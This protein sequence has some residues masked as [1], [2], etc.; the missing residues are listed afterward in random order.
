LKVGNNLIEPTRHA[1]LFTL[2]QG[3]VPENRRASVT[4]YLMA[5]PPT[6]N[7]IMQYYYFFKQQYAAD[8]ATQDLAVL[9]KMRA[10]WKDMANS[11][12]EASFEV[13][14]SWEATQA[15]CYGMFPAYFLSSYVL[16]VRLDGPV[17]KKSLIIE[18]RLADLTEASGTVE[19]EF[20][21]ASVS[22]KLEDGQWNYSVDT[23]KLPPDISVHLRLPVEAKTFS[24]QLDDLVLKTGAKKAKLQGRWLDV[25]LAVGVHKGWLKKSA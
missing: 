22:W 25:P 1:A 9:N 24:A 19:T 16:G 14:H 8:D 5:H 20:G 15:H 17:Q 6:D 10:E 2:D 21:P 11:P 23:T 7:A 18:P 4:A 13:L 12:F 3:V